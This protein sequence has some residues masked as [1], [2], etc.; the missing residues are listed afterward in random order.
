MIAYTALLLLIV[1]IFCL[2]RVSHKMDSYLSWGILCFAIAVFA[3]FCHG[4]ESDTEQI[5]SFIWNSSPSGD[6]KIDVISNSYN[7]NLILPFF[8]LS[9]CAIGF[10]S[11]L[12]YEERK[13][14]YNGMILLNL[15]A[16][17]MMITSNNFVQLLSALFLVD[18]VAIFLGK[19]MGAMREFSLLNIFSDMIMFMALAIINCKIESLDMRQIIHYKNIGQHLDFLC[20]IFLTAVFMKLGICIF[21]FA[22]L[23]LRKIRFHRMQNILF[24]SSP[25]AAIVLL[26]KFHALWSASEYFSDYLNVAYFLT[27]IFSGFGLVVFDNYKAKMIMIQTA[28]LALLVEL[29]RFGGFVWSKNFSILWIVFYL[30]MNS[31][32]VVYLCA[33][34]KTLVSQMAQIKFDKVKS[35]GIP[36]FLVGICIV[37]LTDILEKIYNNTNR[38]YIWGFVAVFMLSVSMILHQIYFSGQKKNADM[39]VKANKLKLQY[40]LLILLLLSGLLLQINVASKIV[41]SFLAIFCVLTFINPLAKMAVLYQIYQLQEI[42]LL[43]RLNN[44]MLCNFFQYA[45]KLLWLLIDWKLLEKFITGS[46]VVVFQFFIRIFRF[47]HATW[48]G[49]ILFTLIMLIAIFATT[50][51]QWSFS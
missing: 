16:L 2:F 39:A 38:W 30:F 3:N 8:F 5:F 23:E 44:R 32:H 11:S 9:L 28:F 12:R 41:W 33:K 51:Y 19:N 48:S 21:Q 1:G 17:I 46:C 47:V 22:A 26:L 35:F 34:R 15:V 27:L 6:I 7:Y 49:R 29:L 45:G 14:A 10:N 20:L 18:I 42:G 24:V 25:A 13:N 40:V 43:H 4:L 36:F 50:Y 37:L 31:M